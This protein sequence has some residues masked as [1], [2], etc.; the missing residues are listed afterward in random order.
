MLLSIADFAKTHPTFTEA[1]LR[2]MRRR[3][4]HPCH[5]AFKC[6]GKRIYIDEKLFLAQLKQV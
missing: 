4:E 1:S 3:R 2:A 5:K 6:L